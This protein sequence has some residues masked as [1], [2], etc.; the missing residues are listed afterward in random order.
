MMRKQGKCG[1]VCP[2]TMIA[3]LRYGRVSSFEKNVAGFFRFVSVSQGEMR[4]KNKNTLS[5]VKKVAGK[6]RVEAW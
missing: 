1:A 2:V 3:P 5:R 4:P 6:R